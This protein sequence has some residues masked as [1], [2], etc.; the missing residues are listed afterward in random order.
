MRRE[1]TKPEPVTD[2]GEG[3]AGEARLAKSKCEGVGEEDAIASA[4]AAAATAAGVLSTPSAII[5]RFRADVG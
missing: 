5:R 4:A 3:I 2:E 1:R